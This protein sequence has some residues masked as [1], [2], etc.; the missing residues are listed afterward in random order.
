MI[1]ALNKWIYEIAESMIPLLKLFV[2]VVVGVFV[3]VCVG[4]G[5]EYLNDLGWIPHNH[6]T[7]I[8][9]KGEWMQGEFRKCQMPLPFSITSSAE[10][11]F[12]GSPPLLFCNAEGDGIQEYLRDY[13]PYGKGSG[14]FHNLPVLYH[15]RIDRLE[16]RPISW[17]CQRGSESLTCWALN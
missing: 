17:K 16:L 12:Q 13:L 2:F 9:I 7:P 11:K 5:Y 10:T 8:W 4:R 1:E 3:V 14:A 6:D 15:G